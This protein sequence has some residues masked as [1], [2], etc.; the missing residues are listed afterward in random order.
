MRGNRLEFF[1]IT[2]YSRIKLRN[3]YEFNYHLLERLDE[4]TG[5]ARS[6]IG[7]MS[8]KSKDF[9][10]HVILESRN[11][12]MGDLMDVC[13]ALRIPVGNFFYLKGTEATTTATA[14]FD[15]KP[16]QFDMTI[17]GELLRGEKSRFEVPLYKI[18]NAAGN[19][20]CRNR[21]WTKDMR[22]ITAQG[23]VKLC[24]GMCLGMHRI[25]ACPMKSV[26]V[27]FTQKQL[28]D[29]CAELCKE[30]I[31]YDEKY[32]NAYA[33]KYRAA[34]R[35]RLQV[36]AAETSAVTLESIQQMLIEIKQEQQEIKL[37]LE[38]LRSKNHSMSEQE[39]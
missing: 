32:G 23:L 7:L 14:V 1:Y 24:N 13:D 25:I 18:M 38:A 35:E 16:A 28:E 3:M 10:R 2:I 4:V 15:Y 21:K 34:R 30:R 27:A 5:I 39:H 6:R 37:Q 17:L 31:R 9:M 33:P 11:I 20:D 8:G 26:P 12:K 29:R 36:E 19:A 22:R